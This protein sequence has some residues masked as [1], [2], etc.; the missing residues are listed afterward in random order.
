MMPRYGALR[1]TR[2]V[3][4]LAKLRGRAV[5]SHMHSMSGLYA[6]SWIIFQKAD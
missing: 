4:P 3:V 1:A 2:N 5:P 6:V